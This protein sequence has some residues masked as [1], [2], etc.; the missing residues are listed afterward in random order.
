MIT[1][2]APPIIQPL[3]TKTLLPTSTTTMKNHQISQLRVSSMAHPHQQVTLTCY[4][5][6]NRVG[7]VIGRQGVSILNIQ[8]EASKKSWGHGGQVRVSIVGTYGSSSR[9]VT[10]QDDSLDTVEQ[11]EVQTSSNTDAAA[12]ASDL[13]T[14]VIIRADPCGAFAAAKLLLPLIDY[15]MDDV[16]LDIPIHRSK[17]SSIIGRK[18]F[19]IASLSADY[20]VRIMVPYRQSSAAATTGVGGTANKQSGGKV[21]EM[22]LFPEN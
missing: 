22:P 12:T 15:E 21:G 19:M 2:I 17:H 10:A 1:T 13:W 5:P 18:G 9:D 3:P 14:P 20:K 7:A 6:P 11:E 16:V 4:I 8:R